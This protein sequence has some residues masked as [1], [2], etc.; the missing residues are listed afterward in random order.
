MPGVSKG[1]LASGEFEVALDHHLR[2]FLD[3]GAGLPA[4]LFLRLR[5]IAEKLLDLGRAEVAGIDLDE[6]LRVETMVFLFPTCSK[7]ID[8]AFG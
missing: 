8:S 5:R 1:L 2:E 4:E 7:N 6:V 3:A